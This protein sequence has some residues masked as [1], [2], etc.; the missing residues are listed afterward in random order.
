MGNAKK[1]HV[2]F[3]ESQSTRDKYMKILTDHGYKVMVVEQTET[4]RQQKK[5]MQKEGQANAKTESKVIVVQVN[6]KKQFF[7]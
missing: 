1:L 3:P 4:P 5:R 6:G 2:G 7:K